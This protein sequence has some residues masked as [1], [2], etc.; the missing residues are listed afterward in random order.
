MIFFGTTLLAILMPELFENPDTPRLITAAAG[1]FLGLLAF[2]SAFWIRRKAKARRLLEQQEKAL[3]HMGPD[4]RVAVERR[5]RERV[6]AI[7][8][9]VESNLQEAWTRAYRRNRQDLAKQLR[10]LSRKAARLRD[11][12]KAASY[13]RSPLL[14]RTSVS[15]EEI[16][17][18]LDID[19]NLLL[20]GEM[21]GDLSQNLYQ[22]VATE[23]WE[24]V[25]GIATQMDIGLQELQSR[26][27]QR[28]TLLKGV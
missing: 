15:P 6:A 16:Q 22:G 8:E 12:L 23:T 10:E 2:I 13:S 26:L 25:A 4:Q 17:P 5:V 3:R 18:W 14:T 7:L 27:V 9:Q 24:Q 28:D 21:L 1:F 11:D 19:E 20:Q